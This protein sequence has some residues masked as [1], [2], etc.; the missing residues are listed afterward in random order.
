LADVHNLTKSPVFDPDPEYGL[1]TLGSEENGY[2]VVDGAFGSIVRAYP[3]P[4]R[5]VRQF[6]PYVSFVISARMDSDTYVSG[7]RLGKRRFRLNLH[8]LTSR[9]RM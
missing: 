8:S 6:D 9:R 2:T 4:H 7:S 5:V 1:G 3:K